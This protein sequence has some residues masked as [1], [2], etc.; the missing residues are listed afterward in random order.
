MAIARAVRRGGT[1]Y[2]F[3]IY[4]PPNVTL[5]LEFSDQPNVEFVGTISSDGSTLTGIMRDPN[6]SRE[7]SLVRRRN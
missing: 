5:T 7:L 2:H 6:R 1:V 3:R 4:E